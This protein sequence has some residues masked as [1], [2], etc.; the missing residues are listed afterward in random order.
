[1]TKREENKFEDEVVKA[2]HR[3]G[4]E[5]GCVPLTSDLMDIVRRAWRQGYL[6]GESYDI[7]EDER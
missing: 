7:E 6:K 5:L 3:H 4:V 2:L 1:M